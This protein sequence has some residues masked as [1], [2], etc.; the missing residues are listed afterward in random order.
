MPIDRY[1]T[2]AGKRDS[3]VEDVPKKNRATWMERKAMVVGG[4]ENSFGRRFSPIER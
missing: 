2:V 1:R 3:I 4:A